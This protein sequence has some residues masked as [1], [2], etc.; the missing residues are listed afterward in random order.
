MLADMMLAMAWG[1]LFS[2]VITLLL[3][4]SLYGF[5][6]DIKHAIKKRYS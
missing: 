3:I 2:T 6:Q 1:L 5:V 4:P